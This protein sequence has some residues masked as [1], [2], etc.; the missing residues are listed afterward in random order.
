M[1]RIYDRVCRGDRKRGAT[2][3]VG[4]HCGSCIETWNLCGYGL[5]PAACKATR[6]RVREKSEAGVRALVGIIVTVG[7]S[8]SVRVGGR[9]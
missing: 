8:A 3:R 7:V 6:S 2:Q 1:T 4:A 5:T 9:G